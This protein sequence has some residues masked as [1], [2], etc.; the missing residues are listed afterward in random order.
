ML[1]RGKHFQR[2][3]RQLLRLIQGGD[4]LLDEAVHELK[5]SRSRLS[6]WMDNKRFRAAL[7]RVLR[8]SARVARVEIRMAAAVARRKLAVALRDPND[9]PVQERLI[10]KG[11]IEISQ[12]DER[13]VAAEEKARAKVPD[14]PLLLHPSMVDQADAFIQAMDDARKPEVAGAEQSEHGA[15]QAALKDTGSKS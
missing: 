9:L 4:K 15:V 12:R 13:I 3:Q 8:Q 14:Q 11:T 10:C 1:R 2:E 5:I 7:R 6:E